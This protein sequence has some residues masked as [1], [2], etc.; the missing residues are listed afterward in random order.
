[1]CILASSWFVCYAHTL[2]FQDHHRAKTHPPPSFPVH[3][4][5]HTHHPPLF[6][7]Q[8]D[9]DGVQPEVLASLLKYIYGCQEDITPATVVDLF[10]A[11][12]HYQ[13]EGLRAECLDLM[14]NNIDVNNCAALAALADG[15]ELPD[16]LE[17]CIKFAATPDNITQ[18]GGGCRFG[19]RGLPSA[20]QCVLVKNT[21][22]WQCSLFGAGAQSSRACPT[23]Y[24][25][26]VDGAHCT[27]GSGACQPIAQQDHQAQTFA[28]LVYFFLDCY[29]LMM[30]VLTSG[31]A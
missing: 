12:D 4:P 29:N 13:V 8:V 11:A 1:M 16:L 7:L 10:R 30:Y 25:G 9:I 27:W 3:H 14:R 21:G 26:A 22:G 23:V 20:H 5:L 18:V 6:A 17:H 15:H 19:C 28:T 24:H 2:V 31:R